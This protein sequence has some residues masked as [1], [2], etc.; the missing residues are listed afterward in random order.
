MRRNAEG[1][2]S[3]QLGNLGWTDVIREHL[4]G[5]R[6]EARPSGDWRRSGRETMAGSRR[7]QDGWTARPRACVQG[8]TERHGVRHGLAGT[9]ARGRAEGQR[10][11]AVAPNL[12]L[13]KPHLSISK[14]LMLPPARDI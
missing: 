8:E 6:A 7:R 11:R 2:T 13:P 9:G 1:D 14:I 4:K 10:P 5:C 3:D 12:F